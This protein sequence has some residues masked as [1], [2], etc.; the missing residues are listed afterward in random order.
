MQERKEV[1]WDLVHVATYAITFDDIHFFLQHRS[2]FE[3]N[4]ILLSLKTKSKR[5]Q[6]Q[7]RA[8][9][10]KGQIIF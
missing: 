1:Q 10:L 4:I 5:I 9:A 7:T 8:C 2:T 3:I 6:N